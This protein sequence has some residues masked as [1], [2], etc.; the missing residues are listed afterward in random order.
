MWLTAWWGEK[1]TKK[2]RTRIAKAWI[3]FEPN[4]HD[5]NELVWMRWISFIVFFFSFFLTR[6]IVHTKATTTASKKGPKAEKRGGERT[7]HQNVCFLMDLSSRKTKNILIS[8]FKPHTKFT[9]HSTNI[10]VRRQTDHYYICVQHFDELWNYIAVRNSVTLTI[11]MPMTNRIDSFVWGRCFWAR[12]APYRI[13]SCVYVA[14][15]IKTKRN[16][17]KRKRNENDIY[18]SVCVGWSE[19]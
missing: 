5:K 19:M 18:I 3:E 16:K 11:H 10:H 14:P 7:A 1:G 12:L 8:S 9:Q 13:V 17:T 6:R 2:I 4:E 15:K